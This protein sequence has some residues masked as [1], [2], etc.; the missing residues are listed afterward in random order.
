MSETATTVEQVRFEDI[1]SVPELGTPEHEVYSARLR[2]AWA[3]I[4]DGQEMPEWVVED[5]LSEARTNPLSVIL[6]YVGPHELL[7]HPEEA[8]RLAAIYP[9]ANEIMTAIDLTEQIEGEE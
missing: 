4:H 6:Q 5:A 3:E 1:T 7:D 9:I 8:L 2:D